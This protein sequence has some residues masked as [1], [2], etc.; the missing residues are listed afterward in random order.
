MGIDPT[1]LTLPQADTVELLR[2]AKN[3]QLF[4]SKPD[5]ISKDENTVIL[6]KQVKWEDWSP[7]FVN[8]VR[9]IPRRDGVPL[10]YIIRDNDFSNLTA[11]KDFLDDYVNN[12]S[13]QGGS[14]TIDAA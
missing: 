6:K 5:T 14:F 2:R 4:M 1:T 9:A 3:H 13:L 8:Y 7:T 10:K 12:T 11:N